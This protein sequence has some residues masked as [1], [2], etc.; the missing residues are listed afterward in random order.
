[1]KRT[2]GFF[3]ACGVLLLAAGAAL[4]WW[5]S[6]GYTEKQYLVDAG[7]CRLEL[8]MLEKSSMTPEADSVVLFHGLAANRK[9]MENLARVFAEM[10]VRVFIPDLPGHGGSK[11]PFTPQR[12]EECS[13]SLLRGLA[14]RGMIAPEHTLLVGH[15]MGGAIAL[16]IAPKF[17]PAG[18]IAISP[19]PMVAAHGVAPENLIYHDPPS[20]GPNTLILAAQIEPKG[21]LANAEDLAATRQDGTVRFKLIPWNTHVGVLFS[22][23]VARE[24]QDWAR[25]VFHRTETTGHLPSE[26]NV[27]GG[28]L[29]I[30]GIVFLVVPFLLEMFGKEKIQ[31]KEVDTGPRK[32]EEMPKGLPSTLRAGLEYAA[33]SIVVM[34]LLKY[35]VPLR[36]IRLFQGDYLASFFLIVG[37]VLI[38]F[39]WNLVKTGV[40][41]KIGVLFSGVVAGI[42]LHLLVTGWFALTITGSWLT[43]E[44]WLRF[45]VFFIAALVFL[46]AL[47]LVLG[48]AEEEHAARRVVL[49]LLYLGIA[50][51]VL[52]AGAFHLH[53]GQIM[54]VL[55]APFLVLF[56]IFLRMGMQVV[57]RLSA[58]PA[59][60]AVFGAILLAGL[61]LVLFPVS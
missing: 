44:R 29:G 54:V 39:H 42:I 17:R 60:A 3:A 50:W 43:A 8:T 2:H 47:E 14:A 38:W 40:R 30:G 51:A 13:L 16:R 33:V 23:T 15:S 22:K 32:T 12:A 57:R 4:S 61:C 41:V 55:L 21:L 48:P 59:V 6:R 5:A 24:C 58:S 45:P 36:F 9:I 28:V 49:S 31:Q 7:S 10:G 53:T 18:V 1:M 25:K 35:W 27:L 37:V 46:Y 11:G 20:L 34:V 19:A 56:S 26:A 52:A